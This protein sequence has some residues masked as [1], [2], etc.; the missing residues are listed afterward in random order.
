MNT[1][2][3]MISANLIKACFAIAIG[4]FFASNAT[5]DIFQCKLKSGKMEMRDFPCDALIRPAAPNSPSPLRINAGPNQANALSNVPMPSFANTAQ[6]EAARKTCLNLMSQYDFTAPMMRCGVN[7]SNCFN[8]ANQESSTI[9]Q[10][11]IARP[12]WQTQQCDLVMQMENP[13]PGVQGCKSAQII[14]PVPFLGTA[15]E[16]IVLSDGSVWKDLSYKYLYLYAYSPTVQ[17]CPAQAKMIL[18]S[19]GRTLSFS[20]MRLK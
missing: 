20:L 6:Y 4:A 8:R 14:E 3:T 18:E 15:E 2:R 16:V 5:A 19:G 7:D 11:L 9:F 10:R 12:E 13:A 17:I 1:L